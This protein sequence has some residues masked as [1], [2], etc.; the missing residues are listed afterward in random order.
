MAEKKKAKG[1]RIKVTRQRRPRRSRKSSKKKK[2]R[3]RRGQGQY[4]TYFPT[5]RT[6]D[7]NQYWQLRA[8]IAGAEAR[9]RQSLQDRKSEESKAEQKVEKL[10]KEV[11]QFVTPNEYDNGDNA[12]RNRQATRNAHTVDLTA[13][14]PHLSLRRSPTTPVEHRGETF[15]DA[16]QRRQQQLRDAIGL[17]QQASVR[18]TGNVFQ[19]WR[20]IAQTGRL[21]EQLRSA[22]EPATPHN[23]SIQADTPTRE[24]VESVVEHGAPPAS[25]RN[26]RQRKRRVVSV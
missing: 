4:S 1:K 25:V 21:Q 6:I 10:E 23:V 7:S 18:S 2:P 17:R 20:T 26:T 14:T 3:R 16:Q 9:V 12:S 11:K 13:Q 24:T 15:E 22:G 8:E 19:R 5:N